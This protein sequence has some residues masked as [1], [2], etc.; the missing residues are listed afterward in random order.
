[1]FPA[2]CSSKKDFSRE[3]FFKKKNF[4]LNLLGR[5]YQQKFPA[6][7]KIVEGKITFPGTHLCFSI[8]NKNVKR[9]TYFLPRRD[10][11]RKIWNQKT[12]KKIIENKSSPNNKTQNTD[13]NHSINHSYI[14]K[15][16]FIRRPFKNLT[17][18]TE[19]WNN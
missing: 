13:R 6:Y 17:N 16:T 2:D 4:L 11:K 1:M 9:I 3:D 8:L 15:Y 19:S 10:N 5:F 12:R 18:Y 14:T 7:S